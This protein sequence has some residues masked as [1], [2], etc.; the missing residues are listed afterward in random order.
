MDKD[1]SLCVS[2]KASSYPPAHLQKPVQPLL[3]P[4]MLP[5]AVAHFYDLQVLWE[6]IHSV[7]TVCSLPGELALAELLDDSLSP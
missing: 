6:V 5:A 3:P 4:G 7:F 1:T 2:R